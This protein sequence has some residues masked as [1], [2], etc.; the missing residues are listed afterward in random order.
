MSVFD[1]LI[2]VAEQ[3]RRS[4]P[5]VVRID[6][7]DIADLREL[8]GSPSPRTDA[9]GV[10][11]FAGVPVHEVPSVLP[12][13][14]RIVKSDGTVETFRLSTAPASDQEDR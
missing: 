12:G 7:F 4:E 8:F 14:A 11:D 2:A 9:L 13:F 5:I 3:L 6:V 1:D 10:A